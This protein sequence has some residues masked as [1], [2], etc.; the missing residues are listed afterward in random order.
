MRVGSSPTGFLTS[1]LLLHSVQLEDPAT[2]LRS[3]VSTA[4]HLPRVAARRP[5]RRALL[6][7]SARAAQATPSDVK[8]IKLTVDGKEVEVPQGCVLPSHPQGPIRR[9]N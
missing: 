8:M 2:M 3:S 6:C 7:T 5:I 9:D 4:R 1:I